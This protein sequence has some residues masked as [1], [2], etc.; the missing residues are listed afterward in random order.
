M[1]TADKPRPLSKADARRIWLRA[2]R[3]DTPA[4]FGAGPQATAAAVEHLGYVQIDTINVIER[5]PS[6]CAVEPDS[7]I[8]ARGPS[9]GPKRRQERVRVLDPCAVLRADP[10]FALLHPGH[11]ASSARRSSMVEVGQSGGPAQGDDADP[12]RRRPDHPRHRRRRADRQGTSVGQ[13]Q[14]VEAGVAARLLHRRAH[15]QRAQRHAQDLRADG[16]VISAGTG[17]RSR[18]R[19]GKSPSICSTARSA[20]RA[21]SASIRSAI[22]MRRA[23]R[24]SAT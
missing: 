4:P 19:R 22:S 20:R 11:E 16:S 17:R 24:R 8:P 9:S 13:P 1:P 14:A 18:P 7:R 12:A 3:L 23:R 21:S 15:H 2:Q 5:S 6:S 10:G